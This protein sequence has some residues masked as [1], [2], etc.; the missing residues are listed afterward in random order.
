M[1]DKDNSAKV[2]PDVLRTITD[3]ARLRP[4]IARDIRRGLL[5]YQALHRSELRPEK[6]MAVDT[7]G[8]HNTDVDLNRGEAKITVLLAWDGS[9]SRQLPP[10][11]SSLQGA[12]LQVYTHIGPLPSARAHDVVAHVRGAPRS[13]AE[14]KDSEWVRQRAGLEEAKPSTVEEVLLAQGGASDSASASG[15]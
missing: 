12:P 4:Y 10:D 9:E 1:I 8:S 13:N 7:E 5:A 14:A 3:A 6:G 11:V 15:E 2:S